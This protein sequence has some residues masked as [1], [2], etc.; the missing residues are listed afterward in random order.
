MQIV[1]NVIPANITVDIWGRGTGKTWG[2]T[3]RKA[4]LRVVC[5][6]RSVGA[7]GCP[8]FTHMMEHI[9]GELVKSWEDMGLV[10]GED[11][12]CFT[13]PLDSWPTPYRKIAKKQ[14]S[15]CIFWRNGSVI[16][17]F[18]YN[19][20]SLAN[21]DSIDWLL[22]DEARLCKKNGID[23]SI[24][25][26]RGNDEHFG[27]L[28]LHGSVGYVSDMPRKPTEFWLLDFQQQMQKARV[29][30][31]M[32]W[33]YIKSEL[34]LSLIG[35]N[36]ERKIKR[37]EKDIALVDEQIN[38]LCMGLT[39][40][41]FA[42][43]L[44]NIHALGPKKLKIWKA[45]S[46]DFDW[47]VSVMNEIQK[48]VSNAFY[49]GIDSD[50]H[51][52]HTPRS[53]F[54]GKIDFKKKEAR[55]WRWDGDLDYSTPLFIGMDYNSDITSIAVA[56][57]IGTTIKL[58]KDW[59]EMGKKR[60]DVVKMFADYYREYPNRK[61]VYFYDNTAIATDAD[62]TIED[63]YAYRTI[64]E[65]KEN[66]FDVEPVYL[67]QTSH[68]YRYSLW[69]EMAAGGT[70]E[71]PWDFQYNLDNCPKW[72]FASSQT[73]TVLRTIKGKTTFGKDK[74]SEDIRDKADQA[75]HITE[76]ADTVVVGIM[77]YFKRKIKKPQLWGIGGN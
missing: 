76:A 62:K 55:N 18:S 11:F 4:Y 9:W 22:I 26:L 37:L 73:Q 67:N 36:S 51:G 72:D 7:I 47:S 29:T 57:P 43:S 50:R 38:E 61:V 25:C 68:Q 14:Y 39:F 64:A 17:L 46:S 3:A 48:K 42:S 34:Q 59:A 27:H 58:V 19:F 71:F 44:E 35:T 41:T 66:G 12:V 54:W 49:A 8:S 32:N 40:V 2:S 20:N 21:G 75:T 28:S 65:L 16:K 70:D 15:R 74:S 30:E 24:K 1:T 23:E 63:S 45:T 56:Q 6:P 69:E 13:K 5:M 31:V 52:Y 53:D 60:S 33:A 10:E 77:N